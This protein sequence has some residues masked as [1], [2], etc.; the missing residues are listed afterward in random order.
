M[1]DRHDPD[2]AIIAFKAAGLVMFLASVL[3]L[4]GKLIG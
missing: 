2:L 4:A 3:A 1:I